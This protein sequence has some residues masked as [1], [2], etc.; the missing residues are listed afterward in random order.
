M[1]LPAKSTMTIVGAS[2]DLRAGRLT[3]EALVGLTHE[4]AS[5]HAALNAIAELRV[6]QALAR[7]READRQL[8]AGRVAGPLH[9]IPVT[10]KDL[11]HTDG[12]TMRAG[13][14]APLPALGRSTAV[15][16]LLDAGAIVIATTNMHEVA[17]GLTGENAWTGDVL[18][19]YA[20]ERQ[21]GGSSSGSAVAVSVGIGLASLATDTGGSIRVPAANCGVVGFKPSYGLVPLD[22]ALPLSP[23]CDHAGPIARSV[24]DARLLTQVLAGRELPYRPMEKTRFGYPAA[25]LNGRLSPSMASAFERLLQELSAAGAKIS[26]IDVPNIELTLEAYTPIVRTEAWQVHRAALTTTPGGFSEPVRRALH[27]GA[28]TSEASYAQAL[29]QRSRVIEGLR[30]AFSSG[31]I[32]ALLLPATPSPPLRRGETEVMLQRGSLPYREAQLA[33]TAPFSL[34]GV[35][36]AAVPFGSV[37]GLPASLQIVTPWGEDALALN[38]AASVEQVV[39]AAAER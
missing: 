14:R 17:L 7:A 13:T 28:A 4:A 38:I 37:C 16:R 20:P 25:Y 9:G 33:L 29:G 23:T 18:N 5:E 35:P 1:T 34:A 19:P 15:D 39:R 22:G 24:E 21:S 32:D 6:E 36:V 27:S 26:F 11:F 8:A 10:V 12:F 30:A 31:A 3:A 2:A